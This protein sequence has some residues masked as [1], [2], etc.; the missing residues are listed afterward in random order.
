M[1][2]ELMRDAAADP[3]HTANVF[4]EEVDTGVHV[5][6]SEL[7]LLLPRYCLCSDAC[8]APDILSSLDML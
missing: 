8:S 7:V 1:K 3:N 2:C 4:F 5:D 6:I